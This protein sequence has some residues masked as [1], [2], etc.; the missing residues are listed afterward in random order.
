MNPCE[1]N[2][3]ITAIS[4]HLFVTLSKKD[5]ACLNIFLSELSKSMF[6]MALFRDICNR[7]E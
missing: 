5:F 3:L 7:E 4:N 1:L 2:V 6:A